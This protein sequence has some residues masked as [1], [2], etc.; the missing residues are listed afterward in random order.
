MP[1]TIADFFEGF[2]LGGFE[3]ARPVL[4]HPF[5]C[6]IFLIN[7]RILSGF[8]NAIAN[9]LS[10]AKVTDS[11]AGM[12]LLETFEMLG[13]EEDFVAFGHRGSTSP[14]PLRVPFVATFDFVGT[15]AI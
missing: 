9:K 6:R 5:D 4:E 15:L 2:D 3:I 11:S 1:F 10:E 13:P 8:A 14:H 7:T 12:F